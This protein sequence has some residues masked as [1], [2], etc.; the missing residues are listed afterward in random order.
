MNAHLPNKLQKEEL[1]GYVDTAAMRQ[2]LVDQLLKDLGVEDLKIELDSAAFFKELASEVAFTMKYF[3]ENQ[4]Q[5]LPNLIYRI[6]LNEREVRIILQN[7]EVDAA[8][9]LADLIITREMKKV[10]YRNVYSGNIKI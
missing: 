6:D 1:Q 2:Q 10:F 9:A 3:I 4:P 8:K 7:P 5:Q